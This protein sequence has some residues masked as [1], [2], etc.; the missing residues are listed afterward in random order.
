VFISLF[1][2]LI[3]ID[4]NDYTSTQDNTSDNDYGEEKNENDV[5]ILTVVAV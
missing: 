3:D 2:F 1:V 4:N 5:F